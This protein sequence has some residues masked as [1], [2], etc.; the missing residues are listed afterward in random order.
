[1]KVFILYKEYLNWVENNGTEIIG[2]F[3]MLENAEQ[4]FNEI[5]EQELKYLEEEEFK[6][7]TVKA[8]RHYAE[9]STV[10]GDVN[11]FIQTKE[12]E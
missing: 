5:Y 12:V 3:N 1:M 8:C 4:K 2:V 6:I 9:I 10:Y 11:I 7:V